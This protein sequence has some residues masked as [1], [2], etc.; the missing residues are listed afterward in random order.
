MS[1]LS[2]VLLLG[3]VGVFMAFGQWINRR[4]RSEIDPEHELDELERK[5]TKVKIASREDKVLKR[6]FLNF[7]F[8]AV[9][10]CSIIWWLLLYPEFNKQAVD[11]RFFIVVVSL[12][13]TS[14]AALATN[15]FMQVVGCLAIRGKQKEVGG[16]TKV[17]NMYVGPHFALQPAYLRQKLQL[18]KEPEAEEIRV[19]GAD[20]V[21]TAGDHF[22]IQWETKDGDPRRTLIHKRDLEVLEELSYT[23][24]EECLAFLNKIVERQLGNDFHIAHLPA[25]ALAIR[26]KTLDY[27][28]TDIAMM[29]DLWTGIHDGNPMLLQQ[30][31][32]LNFELDDTLTVLQQEERKRKQLVE[33]VFTWV[34]T[35]RF[36]IPSA[37]V[38]ELLT[39]GLTLD[40][41]MPPLERSK[42][43][44]IVFGGLYPE[45]CRVY[46]YDTRYAIFLLPYPWN[47]AFDFSDRDWIDAPG[48]AIP[49]PYTDF[50]WI[51]LDYMIIQT[52]PKT[53]EACNILLPIYTDKDLEHQR[54]LLPPHPL[55]QWTS[56]EVSTLFVE[57]AAEPLAREN[58]R[59]K[60]KIQQ[61][62][63]LQESQDKLAQ[64][65][66]KKLWRK[67]HTTSAMVQAVWPLILAFVLLSAVIAYVI[68]E[69]RGAAEAREQLELLKEALKQSGGGEELL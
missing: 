65:A 28:K 30:L 45:L 58:I 3:L 39:N 62:E 18:L 26:A 29:Y 1:L 40:A 19:I 46:R 38:R 5:K 21:I 16:R 2:L 51:F 53:F 4:Q 57:G 69:W 35:S 50:D 14:V 49:M 9:I 44:G 27:K 24:F 63:Q 36:G 22:D 47:D 48:M 23:N 59:L 42:E 43:E 7:Y 64:N 54:G 25:D 32:A 11:S 15:N 33:Q 56:L 60:G 17:Y 55:D 66:L 10:V 31:R 61:R 12:C 67:L 52:G 8:I 13:D 41:T 34:C 6:K 20:G 68:G 37:Q